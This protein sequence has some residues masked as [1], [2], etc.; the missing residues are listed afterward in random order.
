MSESG[1]TALFYLVVQMTFWFICM[2][3]GGAFLGDDG[4]AWGC[5]TGLICTGCGVPSRWI[6]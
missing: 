6:E 3:V 5:I 2:W 4:I 1:T